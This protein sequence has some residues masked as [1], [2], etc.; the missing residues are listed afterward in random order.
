MG[1]KVCKKLPSYIYVL[2]YYPNLA[3]PGYHSSC[4][5]PTSPQTLVW[6]SRTPIQEFL[7][8]LRGR[9]RQEFC[10]RQV[11][12]HMKDDANSR[13][14]KKPRGNGIISARCL[15]WR[16]VQKERQWLNFSLPST[17]NT[18]E[19]EKYH[20]LKAH[21]EFAYQTIQSIQLYIS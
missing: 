21:F 18:S 9:R 7:P 12:K 8:K 6:G 1:P 19:N 14:S 5:W 20:S 13:S 4:Y 2:Q 15:I 10:M 3:K 17:P 11:A 16:L